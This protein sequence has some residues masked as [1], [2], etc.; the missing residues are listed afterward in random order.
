MDLL[1]WIVI[2]CVKSS[3]EDLEM[4]PD[5]AAFRVV[6]RVGV[7]TTVL[8]SLEKDLWDELKAAI[9]DATKPCA[10]S[11]QSSGSSTTE[12]EDQG[13]MMSLITLS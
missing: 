1:S 12:G 11:C 4:K 7:D 10:L 2:C 13:K 6:P 5:C 9:G 8:Q 3:V